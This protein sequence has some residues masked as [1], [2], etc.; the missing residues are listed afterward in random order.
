MNCEDAQLAMTAAID[1]EED[2]LSFERAAAHLEN[3]ESCRWE[4][5]RVKQIDVLFAGQK[6][7]GQTA[8]L[9]RSIEKHLEAQ[10][11]PAPQSKW[12]PFVLLGALL[13]VFKLLEMLPE[14]D[15]GLW[16]KLVPIVFVI[17]LFGLLKENP[18]K[19]KTEL[20]LEAQK[21]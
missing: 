18:F 13:V 10:T 19:I 16:F 14:R 2:S 12:L 9:W 7:R 15:F 20:V 6:R 8:D 17:A 11:K 21:L 3:C 5:E 1:G 4:I